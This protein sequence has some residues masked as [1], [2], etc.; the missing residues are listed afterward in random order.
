MDNDNKIIVNG[1]IA[2]AEGLLRAGCRFFAGYPITPST[3]ILENLSYRMEEE[4]GVFIQ[5]ESELAAINMVF[6]AAAAGARAATAT[7][8]PGFSLYQEGISYMAADDVPSVIINVMREGS[9]LGDIPRSQADYNQMTK[10]GG[11]GDYHCIVLAPCSVSE[12]A[13][14][15]KIAFELAE[16]YKLPVIITYDS[17]IGHMI[18]SVEYPQ[19]ENYNI[20]K[21]D[22]TLKG[23]SDVSKYRT[24]QNVYYHNKN[25]DKYL[26]DKCREIENN[27]QRYEEYMTEDAE[28]ILV[29]FGICARIAKDAVN[30]AREKNIKLGMIRPITLYPFPLNAFKNKNSVKKY[31]SVELNILGQMA[32]DIKLATKNNVVVEHIGKMSTLPTIEE[33][34]NCI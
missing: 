7:S 29:A 11:N 21:Y 20:D 15:P 31:I 4:K 23:C 10:G 33:I 8:G 27:E 34:I 22:W 3:D 12:C 24:I 17:D 1:N 25:Y 14:F 5:A 18:E 32:D 6:G 19:Y 13:N 2:T 16:K 9:G 30:V 28:V 26:F